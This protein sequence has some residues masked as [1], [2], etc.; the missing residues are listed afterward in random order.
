MLC[1]IEDLRLIKWE[2]KRL[3]PLERR[4]LN[5][6][7]RI[8]KFTFLIRTYLEK[9]NIIFDSNVSIL[10]EFVIYIIET[11]KQTN[12]RWEKDSVI[13][14]L[15]HVQRTQERLYHCPTT[16]NVH[17]SSP[18]FQFFLWKWRICSWNFYKIRKER[19]VTIKIMKVLE[20]KLQNAAL[21]FQK[22]KTF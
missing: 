13:L 19:F 18:F 7:K 2:N 16:G 14:T 12:L 9:L 15:W 22:M 4:F 10:R 8:M 6:H 3:R 21:R 1:Q 11:E 20:Y 5:S 17:Q